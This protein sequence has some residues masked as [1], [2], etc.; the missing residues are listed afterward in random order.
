MTGDNS[1]EWSPEEEVPLVEVLLNAVSKNDEQSATNDNEHSANEADANASSVSKKRTRSESSTKDNDC[2][3]INIHVE[4]G[5]SDDDKD[6]K[7]QQQQQQ[8]AAKRMAVATG[9]DENSPV[10]AK[11]ADEMEL[12]KDFVV[13]AVV[14]RKDVEVV[15]EHNQSK[16]ADLE[17]RTGAKITIVAGKDD[18]DIVVDRVL[19]IRGHIDNVSAAYKCV[20][21]GMLAIKEAKEA[22]EEADKQ[23]QQQ[24]RDG[25]GANADTAGS[26]SKEKADVEVIE[27]EDDENTNQDDNADKEASKANEENNNKDDGDGANP[28]TAKPTDNNK[29]RIKLRVLVHHKC[30]GSVMGHGGKTINKIREAASVNIHTSEDTLPRSSERIIE[31]IGA[32]ESIEM[33]IHLIAE[34]LTRD[35]ELYNNADYYVPAA[36]LPSAMTVETH[37]RKRKDGRRPHGGDY[38]HG[39]NH[40]GGGGNRGG[41]GYNRSGYHNRNYNQNRFRGSNSNSNSNSYPNGGRNNRYQDYNRHGQQ[42]NRGNNGPGGGMGQVN[43]MPMGGRQYQY[44]QRGGQYNNNNNGNNGNNGNGRMGNQMGGG[45]MSA[46]GNAAISYAGYAVPA[47]AVYPA[48]TVPPQAMAQGGSGGG[49]NMRG[50]QY[51]TAIAS[52]SPGVVGGYNA[53][54]AA[55]PYQFPAPIAYGYGAAIP[56]V[57]GMS[58]GS[59]NNRSGQPSRSYPPTSRGNSWSQNAQHSPTGGGGPSS[60]NKGSVSRQTIQQMFVP[61]D[62]IGAVIGRRGETINEIR[63]TANVKVDIQ[64]SAQGAKDRLVVITGEYEQVYSAYDMILNK[65]NTARPQQPSNMHL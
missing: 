39:Y 8:Q 62:K 15:F 36:N 7:E 60:D 17:A 3:D 23:Q 9:S 26:N 61:S 58:S 34:A 52:T 47:S 65:I 2:E 13:R 31:I 6:G 25:D 40:Q 10:P 44:K 5:W 28:D 22:N 56:A 57:P 29:G 16:Q 38:H 11:K 27:V 49:G 54:M 18:P 24:Q 4:A 37:Y 63:R 30:V 45:S 1:R 48:Y 53:A 46:N 43:R 59:N 51:G 35:I 20:A 55:S 64:D 14:T 12:L 19:S 21:D 50:M 33:A 32:P 41:H 42:R